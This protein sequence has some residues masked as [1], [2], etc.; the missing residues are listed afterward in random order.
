MEKN[1][2]ERKE[3]EEE[4][5]EILGR[6][7]PRKTTG[8]Q[9]DNDNTSCSRL[10]MAAVK[11]A[12]NKQLDLALSRFQEIDD[13]KVN[14]RDLQKLRKHPFKRRYLLCTQKIAEPKEISKFHEGVIEALQ[15]GVNVNASL[16]RK[17]SEWRGNVL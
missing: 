12:I 8:S 4:S 2:V 15:I 14:L 13:L 10:N 16:C 5:E 9:T 1:D 11:G 6:K 3:I 7:R 17:I